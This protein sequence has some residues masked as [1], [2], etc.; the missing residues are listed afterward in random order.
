MMAFM[1]CGTEAECQIETLH[2]RSEEIDFLADD[3][4]TQQVTTM[5]EAFTPTVDPP[6]NAK[7]W[8]DIFTPT[9]D[10]LFYSNKN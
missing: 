7:K 3:V 8:R 2:L 10:M 9:N 1:R 4:T 6:V 5:L